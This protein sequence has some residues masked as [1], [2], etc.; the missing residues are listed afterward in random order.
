MRRTN[1]QWRS[2]TLCLVGHDVDSVGTIP[3]TAH[4]SAPALSALGARTLYMN[5]PYVYSIYSIHCSK[6]NFTIPSSP[7]PSPR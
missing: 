1:A 6:A 4:G 5:R 2:R 3:Q 7:G